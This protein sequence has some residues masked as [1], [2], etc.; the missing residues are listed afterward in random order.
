MSGFNRGEHLMFI[1]S[2]FSIFCSLIHQA[3]KNPAASLTKN[4]HSR[5]G[6]W[7]RHLK[8]R[9]GASKM[10]QQ[11]TALANKPDN[12][13][14]SPELTLFKKSR[15]SHKLSSDLYISAMAHVFLHSSL[16]N[17]MIVKE[18]RISLPG[19]TPVPESSSCSTENSKERL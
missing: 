17:V 18:G 14:S 4:R 6:I 9:E 12:L 7:Y 11:E 5:S 13:N 16:L 8:S 1:H 19:N 10:A 15:D 2:L 3:A